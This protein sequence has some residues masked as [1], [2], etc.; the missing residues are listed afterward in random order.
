MSERKGRKVIDINYPL[1]PD[2]LAFVQVPRDLTQAEAERLCAMILTLPM[3][4]PKES[5][6]G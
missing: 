2:M 5:T 3:P 4:E 1:R 6:D